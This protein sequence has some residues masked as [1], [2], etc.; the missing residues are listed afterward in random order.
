MRVILDEMLPV[1][2][3]DLLPDHDV[4]TARA[5]GYAGLTNGELIRRAVADGYDV[6]V[7]ADL[8]LPAQQNI[9][10]SGIAVILV[11]GSRLAD[12]NPQANDIR[13]AI[14]N[15]TPGAV[16]RIGSPTGP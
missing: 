16:T 2:T 10:A 4:M 12:I 7:T 6:L 11:R 5:A 13:A 15:A 14:A 8:N 3:A 9:R 1:D